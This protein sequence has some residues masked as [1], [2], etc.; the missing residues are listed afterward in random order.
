VRSIRPGEL[1]PRTYW[2]CTQATF[3]FEEADA[4]D[5]AEAEAE[6]AGGL[7][8][9][10]GGGGG[11]GGGQ[12]RVIVELPDGRRLLVPLAVLQQVRYCPREVK[13]GRKVSGGA[14]Q[15]RPRR[16]ARPCGCG[17]RSWD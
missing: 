16:N 13:P 8:W 9:G 11:G 5:A 17:W 7:V 2:R 10:G 14:S 3:S 1:R 12:P 4:L 6:A 15:L